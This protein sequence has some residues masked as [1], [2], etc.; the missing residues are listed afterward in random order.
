M[1]RPIAPYNGVWRA[2]ATVRAAAT[3]APALHVGD[4]ALAEDRRGA[5]IES[6]GRRGQVVTVGDVHVLP[7]VGGELP[8]RH[9]VAL[10]VRVGAG[11]TS[12]V[13]RGPRWVPLVRRPRGHHHIHGA[14]GEGEDGRAVILVLHAHRPFV[15]GAR[16]HGLVTLRQGTSRHGNST[17]LKERRVIYPV[18]DTRDLDRAFAQPRSKATEHV[19]TEP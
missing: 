2:A 10:G 8:E 15:A 14:A 9:Q 4:P 16:A 18:G 7:H 19:D 11:A 17:A 6:L 5:H 1:R 12:H 3:L 13:H